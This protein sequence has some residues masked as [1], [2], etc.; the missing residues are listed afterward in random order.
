MHFQTL[1]RKQYFYFFQNDFN[2][3]SFHWKCSF[4]WCLRQRER[5]LF[6]VPL[7]FVDSIIA[8]FVFDAASFILT[9]DWVHQLFQNYFV[10]IYQRPILIPS[11]QLSTVVDERI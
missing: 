4:L 8:S 7:N 9:I 6:G 10:V 5:Y 11:S 1:S 2:N 3:R